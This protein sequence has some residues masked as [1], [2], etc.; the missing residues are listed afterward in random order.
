MGCADLGGS[1]CWL[2]CAQQRWSCRWAVGP[3]PR[4]ILPGT[5]LL[6]R[7]QCQEP[8]PP[9]AASGQAGWCGRAHQQGPGCPG[10]T[11]EDSV[12][13]RRVGHRHPGVTIR[14]PLLPLTAVQAGR[15]AFLTPLKVCP[16][17]RQVLTTIS[18]CGADGQDVHSGEGFGSSCV[19]HPGIEGLDPGCSNLTITE[20][21]ACCQGPAAVAKPP[22]KQYR[23]G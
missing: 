18:R 17:M 22:T 3:Q 19:G 12:A 11:G 20:M 7:D 2:V 10:R 23:H 6:T 14:R 15:T 5:V 9:L 4:D 16:G 1:T 8:R 21:T 13:V